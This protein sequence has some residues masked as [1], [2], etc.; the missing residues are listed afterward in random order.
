MRNL[1]RVLL[2]ASLAGNI[3]LGTV[4]DRVLILHGPVQPTDFK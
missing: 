1:L 3:A 2:L 4:V